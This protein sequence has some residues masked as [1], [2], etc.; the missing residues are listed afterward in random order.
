MSV[1]FRNALLWLFGSALMIV[2][3]LSSMSAAY[4][5][6]HYVPDNEDA[7]YHARRILDSV[8]NHAP[9][10]QFDAKIHAPEGSW[11]TWPWGFDTLMAT[12][13]GWFGPFADVDHA[14]RVL[15]NI[16]PLATV[17][18]VLL[19]VLI[20]RQL[21]LPLL[22][23]AVLTLGFA[24]LPA[25]FR[26]FSVGNVDHHFAEMTWTLGTWAAG[27]WFCRE[28]GRSLLPALV[29]G[30][31]LGSAVA[32][33]NGLFIL[34]LPLC[35]FFA[36]RWLRGEELPARRPMI[37]F[38]LALVV[39]TLAS[40]IPSEPWR[41]GFFEFYTLSWFHLYIA[42]LVAAFSVAL[43]F[44]RRTRRSLVV[45][46][47]LAGLALLPLFGMLYLAGTFVSGNLTTVQDISEAKSP[48]RLL[49]ER[50]EAEST[51]YMSWLMVLM[52]PMLLLNLWW[53][54]R[55]REPQLQLAA[56]LSVFGL[57][58]FQSQYRFCVFGVLPMLLTPLLALRQWS[59][60]RPALGRF[61]PAAVLALFGLA[62]LPTAGAWTTTWAL[63]SNLGYA[64]VR[65]TWPRFAQLCREHPGIAFAT[66]EAGH[67]IRYHTDC[68][69]MA[70]V[71]L[72]T[73]QHAAKIDENSHLLRLTPAQFLTERRDI[74][75]VFV[76]H[77]VTISEEVP[78]HETP[79]LEVLRQ[80]LAPLERDLLG[81]EKD[82]P[83]EFEKRWEVRSPQ[84]QIYSRLYEIVRR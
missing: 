68:A 14:N 1:A 9:V 60:A 24:L 22:H 29:L 6:G 67:W 3:A 11:L 69:V 58:L 41:R 52:L 38:A 65:S 31:V 78:G 42:V 21:A 53:A 56:I 49:I 76:F 66:I 16:S 30:A 83:P 39:A 40:C 8:L 72:L 36:L 12:I 55:R 5:D 15:M 10:A 81:P 80:Q 61:A 2:A 77:G 37:A 79:V 59:E 25:A 75:Y 13:T 50:G 46:T 70:N 7:F 20:A 35:I 4:V 74:R 54:W 18:A 44:F 48:Y 63:G 33:Q 28:G 51:M 71:F 64:N 62:Y 73:P 27:L 84:G 47:V 17:V 57:A 43:T 45:M 23:S 26:T 34:Q 32:I 19:V 82:I